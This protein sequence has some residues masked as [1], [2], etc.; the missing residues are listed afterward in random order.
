M[1]KTLKS[2]YVTL[3]IAEICEARVFPHAGIDGGGMLTASAVSLQ[4]ILSV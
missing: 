1:Q 3:A 2:F 4:P